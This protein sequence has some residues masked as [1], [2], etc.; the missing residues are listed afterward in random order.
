MA[1]DEFRPPGRWQR[2]IRNLQGVLRVFSADQS[3]PRSARLVAPWLSDVVQLTFPL[4]GFVRVIVVPDPSAGT[5]FNVFVPD[6]LVWK[7]KA[8]HFSLISDATVINR[9]VRLNVLGVDGVP[10]VLSGSG[11]NHIANL[12]V[13]YVVGAYGVVGGLM[14]DGLTFALPVPPDLPMLAGFAFQSEIFNL[15][16][17]DVVTQVRLLVEESGR[18]D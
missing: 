8:A 15:Q 9:R 5:N 3:D 6:G 2:H 18:L 10:L 1:R 13:R 14:A 17:G 7:L 11:G 16:A 4:G 12:S